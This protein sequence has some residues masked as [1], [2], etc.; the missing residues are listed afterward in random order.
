MFQIF[1]KISKISLFFKSVARI[2]V[3]VRISLFFS[4]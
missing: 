2:L 4:V 3:I 1:V